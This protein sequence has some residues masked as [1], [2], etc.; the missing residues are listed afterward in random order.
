[1]VV[2]LQLSLCREVCK[3]VVLGIAYFLLYKEDFRIYMVLLGVFLFEWA[4][5]LISDASLVPIP[6]LDTV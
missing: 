6:G 4:V 3:D 5:S 1:M 2:Q